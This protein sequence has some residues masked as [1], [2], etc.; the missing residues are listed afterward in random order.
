MKVEHINKYFSSLPFF[1]FTRG[2]DQL[3][4]FHSVADTET[5]ILTS[6]LKFFSYFALST[7]VC[8]KYE[9]QVHILVTLYRTLCSIS[10]L[11]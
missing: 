6:R 9:G 2:L 4:F 1:S 3:H 5:D 8:D 10:S 7:I 11:L